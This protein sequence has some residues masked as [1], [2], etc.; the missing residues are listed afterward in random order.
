MNP[1]RPRTLGLAPRGQQTCSLFLTERV[2][3][4]TPQAG[5]VSLLRPLWSLVL[6]GHQM[7]YLG[8]YPYQSEFGVLIFIGKRCRG[9]AKRRQRE[10]LSRRCLH[11]AL[12]QLQA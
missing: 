5:L 12:N 11:L 10:D 7:P 2:T 9:T 1:T 6:A 4:S 8:G 3:P